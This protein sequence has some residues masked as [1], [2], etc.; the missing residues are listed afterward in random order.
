MRLRNSIH[1]AERT[2]D[3]MVTSAPLSKEDLRGTLL[4]IKRTTVETL[5]KP[6]IIRINLEYD[7]KKEPFVYPVDQCNWYFVCSIEFLFCITDVRTGSTQ[8]RASD[9]GHSR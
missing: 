2:P 3:I 1:H 9:T 4:A 5:S 7:G 6:A 8:Q